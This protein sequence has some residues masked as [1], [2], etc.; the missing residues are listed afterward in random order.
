MLFGLRHPSSEIC[1]DEPARL[2][3]LPPQDS[4][5]ALGLLPFRDTNTSM[6]VC[7]SQAPAFRDT[8]TSMYVVYLL[9]SLNILVMRRYLGRRK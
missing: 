6:Y 1:F 9:C 7:R 2:A 4:V 3:P 5:I 8:N